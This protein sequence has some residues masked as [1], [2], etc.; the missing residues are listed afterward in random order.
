[1]NYPVSLTA[2]VCKWFIFPPSYASQQAK[3][4]E[5]LGFVS[6][7]FSGKMS[8]RPDLMQLQWRRK[9]TDQQRG[10]D[11][12]KEEGEEEGCVVCGQPVC[13]PALDLL[14]TIH[15]KRKVRCYVVAHCA[16]RL[17]G[18]L[19]INLKEFEA[20]KSAQT[21][22]QVTW[23]NLSQELNFQLD[24]NYLTWTWSYD[25]KIPST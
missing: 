2:P 17:Y 4:R 1:M 24:I 18:F 8:S 5:E 3:S 9:H 19:Q 7:W 12:R 10:G 14:L 22:D 21:R 25:A 11:G 16:V 20:H 13:R 6:K 23:L 15:N